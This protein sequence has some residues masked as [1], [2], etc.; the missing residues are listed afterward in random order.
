MEN[1]IDSHA[2]SRAVLITGGGKRIGKAIVFSLAAQGWSVVIHCH[3]SKHEANNVAEKAQEL[4]A[5]FA[6]VVTRDLSIAQDATSLIPHAQSMLGDIPLSALINNASVFE[7]DTLQSLTCTSWDRHINVNLRAP[8]L[9]AG[10]FYTNLL[11]HPSGQKAAQNGDGSIINITDQ[12]SWNPN[13]DFLSYTLSK[14]GLWDLTRTLAISLA[15]HV[16]VNAV[17]PGMVL[18]NK[19]Q[20]YNHFNSQRK[21]NILDNNGDPV[22]ICDAI[23]YILS[24]RAMTG[25]M[26]AIDGGM[27]IAMRTDAIQT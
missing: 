25:Q 12:S 27:H 8:A 4:G 5:P 15:P 10:A 14:C 9:L 20:S 3:T 23:R 6:C 7:P 17:A 1:H 2:E 21:R 22:D 13:P 16:R 18:Q 19:R 26:L 24:A 11:Q